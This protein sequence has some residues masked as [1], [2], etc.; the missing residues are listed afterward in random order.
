MLMIDEQNWFGFS[1]DPETFW[2]LY[3]EGEN[4]GQDPSSRWGEDMEGCFCGKREGSN[5]LWWMETFV[6]GVSCCFWGHLQIHPHHTTRAA[7]TCLKAIRENNSLMNDADG[8]EGALDNKQ[9]K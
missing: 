6:Q 1:G 3:A 2:K 8:C 4:K 9:L 5:F 7:S